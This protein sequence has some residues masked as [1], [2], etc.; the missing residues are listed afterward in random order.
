MIAALYLLPIALLLALRDRAWRAA[1]ALMASSV[2]LCG[3]AGDDAV[4]VS[5]GAG[6]GR[7]VQVC[8][9]AHRYGGGAVDVEYRKAVSESVE[10]TAAVQ[11]VAGVDAERNPEAPSGFTYLGN[12]GVAPRLGVDHT[13]FGLHGGV[14]AGA[15]VTN[16]GR[17]PLFPV[18]DLRVGPRSSVFLD[19]SVGNTFAGALPSGWLRVGAGVGLKPTLRG[20]WNHPV[21][22]AGLGDAGVYGWTQLPLGESGML[23]ALVSYGDRDT[24]R[25]A[26]GARVR[27]GS[28]R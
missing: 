21:L 22:R 24:W 15:L 2:V 10:L 23:D 18:M 25:V 28:L 19:M 20:A 13:W 1:A 5:G 6:G 3:A 16:G 26:L 14:I 12:V 9:P 17:E 8:G 11:V 27:F 7:F 4:T